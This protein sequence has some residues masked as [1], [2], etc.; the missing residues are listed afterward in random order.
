MNEGE[1]QVRSL[2]K[3]RKSAIDELTHLLPIGRRDIGQP[4]LDIAMAEFFRVEFGRVLGQ[5]LDD[6][7]GMVKEIAQSDFTGMNAGLITD[8]HKAFRHVVAQVFQRGDHVLAIHTPL[9][10]AFIDLARNSQTH[11]R[12]QHPPITGHAAQD[13]SLAA[14]RPGAPEPFEKREAELVIKYDVYAVPPRL[15]LSEANPAPARRG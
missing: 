1:Q 9:K 12:G 5:G 14:R 13:G 11:G 7:L 4:L 3:S 10:M 15:F 6:D 2:P 8:Q